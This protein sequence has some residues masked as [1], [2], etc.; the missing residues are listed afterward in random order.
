MRES[1]ES[2]DDRVITVSSMP[3]EKTLHTAEP[4]ALKLSTL[5]LFKYGMHV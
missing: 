2:I 4:Y 5:T 1:A 3:Q